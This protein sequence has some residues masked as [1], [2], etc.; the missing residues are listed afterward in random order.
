MAGEIGK[1]LNSKTAKTALLAV[2]AVLLLAAVWLVFFGGGKEKTAESAYVPTE[3]EAR[4]CRLLEEVEGVGSVTAMI[5]E[6]DGVP[7]SAIVVFGG[8]D[9]ILSRMRVLDITAKALNLKKSCI[10]VYPAE[11]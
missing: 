10:Q 1:L 5:S 2:A 9:S 3:R 11:K 7:I 6:E 4:L 8:A